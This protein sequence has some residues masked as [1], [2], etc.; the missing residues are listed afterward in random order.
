VTQDKKKF[1]AVL[2]GLGNMGRNHFRVLNASPDF[3]LV[4]VVDPFVSELPEGAPAG[5]RLMHDVAALKDMAFDVAVV[6]TPTESHFA[7]VQPFLEMSKHLL[8]EKPLASSSA[9]A[10]E[11]AREAAVRGLKMAV[12]NVERCNPAVVA[13]K[14]VLDTGVLGAVVHVHGTRAG[15]FPAH[16]KEGNQV[17]LDLAV[18]ELDVVR[19]VLGPLTLVHSICH[20][21]RQ[22]SIIDLAEIIVRGRRGATAS[23]HVNWLSPQRIR[24][25]R[26]TGTAAV[27]EINYIDQ[28]CTLYGSALKEGLASPPSLQGNFDASFTFCDKFDVTVEK[29]E[30]LKTQLSEFA[31]YLRGEPHILCWGQEA[32]D[33]LLLL[34]ECV[35]KSQGGLPPAAFARA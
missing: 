11:I 18:H 24:T 3:E 35:T 1:R 21:T 17:V 5:V 4:A 2:V 30:S 31:R 6:A 13:L 32:A 33:S 14:Q 15:R 19:M 16:V 29:R 8:V 7:T 28:S 25:L 12:G 20:A 9:E 26:V 34:E 27:C 23:V 10:N 22:E